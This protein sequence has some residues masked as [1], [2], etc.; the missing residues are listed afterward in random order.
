MSI[1]A[2]ALKKAQETAVK[3]TVP[4][5]PVKKTKKRNSHLYSIIVVCVLLLFSGVILFSFLR[6]GPIETNTEEKISGK[7]VP[8]KLTSK[9]ESP[10]YARE[11]IAEKE[12]KKIIAPKPLAIIGTEDITK[13]IQLN[14]IMYTPGK[15]LVVINDN[16]WAEGDTV[17]GFKILRIEENSVK[18]ASNGQEFIIKLKR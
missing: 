5:Q 16:I 13:R 14:G 1:I 18:V 11:T 2:E 8:E 4:L 6:P 12:E 17:S 10:S 7:S 15:P 3:R 9:P